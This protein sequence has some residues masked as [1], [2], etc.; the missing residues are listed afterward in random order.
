MHFQLTDQ[1]YLTEEEELDLTESGDNQSISSLE[2]SKY[3]STGDE[4]SS[5]KGYQSST[6][7]E[8]HL[9]E[10]EELQ[11]GEREE[12][13]RETVLDVQGMTCQSCVQNIETNIA[14][15]KGVLDI[16]VREP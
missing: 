12:M 4:S 10:E 3:Q 7:E 13:E 9:T 8:L 2:K 11:V 15:E 14:K 1:T 6:S 16:K 5:G